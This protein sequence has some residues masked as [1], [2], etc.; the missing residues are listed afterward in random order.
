MLG[1]VVS[2]FLKGQKEDLRIVFLRRYWYADSVEEAA[3]HMGWSVGKAKSVLF[4][5]RKKLKVYL[6]QEGWL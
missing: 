3:K 2:E 6:E 1:Q 4:R 5:M